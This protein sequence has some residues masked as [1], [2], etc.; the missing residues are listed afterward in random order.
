[1]NRKA[2]SPRVREKIKLYK[3]AL[4]E[5]KRRIEC[6]NNALLKPLLGIR[7]SK[8]EYELEPHIAS[9]LRTSPYSNLTFQQLHKFLGIE[10]N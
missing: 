9:Q 5:K 2:P 8:G 7:I 10:I 6:K 1:M 4:S 3:S